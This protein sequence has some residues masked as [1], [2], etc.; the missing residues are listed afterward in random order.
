[1]ARGLVRPQAQVQTAREEEGN[2]GQRDRQTY[3][4]PGKYP[5]RAPL[6][7]YAGPSRPVLSRSLRTGP[8]PGTQGIQRQG[9]GRLKTLATTPA[10]NWDIWLTKWEGS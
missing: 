1:M 2:T 4:E 7:P 3:Q 5:Q 8:R 6:R 10:R 9:I